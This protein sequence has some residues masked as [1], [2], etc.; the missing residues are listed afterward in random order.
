MVD[1]QRDARLQTPRPYFLNLVSAVRSSPGAPLLA[2]IWR[3]PGKRSVSPLPCSGEQ[4]DRVAARIVGEHIGEV[5]EERAALQPA[6]LRY[7]EQPL[8]RALAVLGLA[9]QGE[10]AVDD[11]AAQA[12]LGGVVGRLDAVELAEGPQRRP[13]REQVLGEGA[14]VPVTGALAR[15]GLE[16]PPQLALEG[17]DRV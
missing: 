12:A 15:V 17:S 5:G 2:C 4:R 9:A 13:Q 10:L 16:Q 14:G 7:G 11:R 3:F 8:C 6:A 1:G